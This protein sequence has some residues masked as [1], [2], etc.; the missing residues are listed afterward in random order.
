MLAK[1]LLLT[2]ALFTLSLCIWK[3]AGLR[4]WC[5]SLFSEPKYEVC[6]W[7]PVK[8]SDIKVG[9]AFNLSI[10]VQ[11]MEDEQGGAASVKRYRMHEILKTPPSNRTVTFDDLGRLSGRIQRKMRYPEVW[12]T[13]PQDV[14]YEEVVQDIKAGRPVSYV[15]FF[16]KCE[17]YSE[18]MV[19]YL[20]QN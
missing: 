13:Y 16:L 17:W 4:D 10:C 14:P 20:Q 3:L 11:F 1:R 6:R 19:R 8:V 15:G 2:F 5:H 9:D 12:K 18:I 7:P